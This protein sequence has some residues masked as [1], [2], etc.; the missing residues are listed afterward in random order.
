M[1]A[2]DARAQRRLAVA[3]EYG[4][5]SKLDLEAL[6]SGVIGT[7]S[8]D[9]HHLDP[10]CVRIWEGNA[11]AYDQLTEEGT[12]ELIESIELGQRFPV[13]VRRVQGDPKHEFELIAGCRRHFAVG[14]LRARGTNAPLV[15]QIT[16][17]G[18]ESAFLLADT[19]NR[20]RKDVTDLERARNFV[21]AL[22]T[23]Y[24]D[25]LGAMAAVLGVSKGWLSKTISVGKLPDVVVEAFGPPEALKVKSA[26][27][28]CVALKDEKRRE[29]IL[30]RAKALS[31]TQTTRNRRK[32]APISASDVVRQLLHGVKPEA[33]QPT[34][35]AKSGSPALTL[36][37][38][39]KSGITVRVHAG[40]GADADEL[41]SAFKEALDYLGSAA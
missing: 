31:R 38:H 6:M 28:I 20:Q 33:S 24:R 8:L 9:L 32:A 1:K 35:H 21:W 34:W 26:Y 10:A 18:D 4:T 22:Q 16:S 11:R 12:R 25:N 23:I 39:S 19:E 15:A 37:Q 30:S 13:I 5:E 14:A 29:T 27:E 7:S 2:K 17:L 41:V 3:P 40:S 36:K